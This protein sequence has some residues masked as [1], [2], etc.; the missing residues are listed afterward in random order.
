LVAFDE[1]QICIAGRGL[2]ALPPDEVL[3]MRTVPLY[4]YYLAKA[5]DG[6]GIRAAKDSY[7]AFLA[8]LHDPDTA[9]PIIVDARRHAE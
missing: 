1:L 9:D 3:A 8:M 2:T 6:L 5:Q 7:R 4:T